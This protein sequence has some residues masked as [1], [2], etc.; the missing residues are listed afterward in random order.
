MIEAMAEENVERQFLNVALRPRQFRVAFLIDPSGTSLALLD[1][2]FE[3]AT[4]VWGGRLFPIIPIINGDISPAYWHLLLTYDPDSIY[5]YST[6]P[7]ALIDRIESE[8]DPLRIEKH[9]EYL[10]QRDHPHFSPHNLDSFVPVESLIPLEI[11][12]HWF[13]K[14]VL[15]TYDG[16]GAGH[17]DPL[18]ARN[19]G[20]LQKGLRSR[21][22]SE[23]VA[24]VSF[25]RETSFASFLEL[26][27]AAERNSVVFPHGLAAA[28][29][30]LN[31]RR[32]GHDTGYAIFV[33]ESMEDWVAHWNHIFTVNPGGRTGWKALC[34]P[35][36]QLSDPG[37]QPPLLAFLRRCTSRNGQHP[38]YITWIS[39]EL[40]EQE[41]R[42]L[43]APY[44]VRT[45][46]AVFR[47]L[48]R[49]EWD[50]PMLEPNDAISYGLPSIVSGD[51]DLIQTSIQQIPREGGLLNPPPLPFRFRG[52]GRWMLDVR[53]QYLSKY[54]FYGNEEVTYKL[55]RRNGVARAFSQTPGRIVLHGGLAFEMRRQMPLGIR[56][57]DDRDLLL[58]AI[59]CG[60]RSGHTADLA[61]R[62]LPPAYQ[63]H[64]PSDKAKYCRGVIDLFEGLQTASQYFNSRFWR[65]MFNEL[66]G[67]EIE[68][69]RKVAANK[70]K[71]H[72]ERWTL[73]SAVADEASIERI[74]NHVVRLL[75]HVKSQDGEITL[76]YM[77][78]EFALE[79][80]E[81][82]EKNPEYKS[83]DEM[84]EEEQIQAIHMDL[85]RNLQW[86]VDRGILQQGVVSRCSHCGSRLWREL[87]NL[88]QRLPCD[89]CG[90]EVRTP[91]DTQWIY[92]TNSLMHGAV[93]H[94]GTV[95][96]L[97]ALA[98]L[99]EQARDSYIYSP[100]IQF[101][102]RYEDRGPA[103]EVDL[104][105]IKD[106]K[107]VVG[108]VKTDTGEFNRTE[109]DKLV[110]AAKRLG[111]DEACV[112]ALEGKQ[113]ILA[114]L[115][116][117]ATAENCPVDLVHLWPSQRASEPALH[118]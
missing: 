66:A 110:A 60:T 71:K 67:A 107:V 75:Q 73:D 84:S 33:G 40:S 59:G 95:A 98:K 81:F 112:F 78:E 72:P 90:A 26:V 5:T 85:K 111:A 22:I 1:A 69:L 58:V 49:P 13:R 77:E 34:L 55:P 116:A 37:F 4:G 43:S 25:T 103:V 91:V 79:R 20:V 70:I 27:T 29:C 88:A 62:Q 97:L 3:F 105:C 100:G 61:W 10:M 21:T 44:R 96:L 80:K 15:A 16:R 47:F 14:P 115:C 18:I 83:T 50:F 42:D 45:L 57:P 7:Q 94:H 35:A 63:D 32:E 9:P 52:D 82:Y 19:F 93:A 104:V 36:A 76:K 31:V 56:I 113:E 38:P 12:P 28:R 2:I 102:E 74:A 41:L 6:L 108:E 106:G 86:F 109:I 51:P 53:I 24:Q 8:I 92:R 87:T 101:Y 114:K 17:A 39:R 23:D 65:R 48:R 64:A 117:T 99:R 68:H 11:S 30:T 54:P 46:D 118:V 89:G